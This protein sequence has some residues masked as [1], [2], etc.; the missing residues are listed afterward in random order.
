[1]H[2]D[3]CQEQTTKIWS[4]IDLNKL[5]VAT[6]RLHLA[7][8]T[9]LLLPFV[10]QNQFKV[11]INDEFGVLEVSRLVDN[12]VK[13]EKCCITFTRNTKKVMPKKARTFDPCNAKSLPRLCH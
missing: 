2:Q 5:S 7:K 10:K 12:T 3:L 13:N 9:K 1:M 8:N 11:F 4:A 6:M